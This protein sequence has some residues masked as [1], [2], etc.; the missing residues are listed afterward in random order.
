ML[1]D[2]KQFTEANYPLTNKANFSNLGSI[3][4]ISKQKPLISFQPDD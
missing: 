1:I 4:E 3:I 2:K